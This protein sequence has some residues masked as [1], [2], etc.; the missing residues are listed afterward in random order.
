[1]TGRRQRQLLL[2]PGFRVME[3]HVQSRHTAVALSVASVQCILPSLC[4]LTA[5]ALHRHV[6]LDDSCT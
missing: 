4:V 1:L 3:H 2:R 5:A 6:E